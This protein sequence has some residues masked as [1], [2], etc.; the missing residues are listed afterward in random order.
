MLL[1]GTGEVLT[2]RTG[3]AAFT[4]WGTIGPRLPPPRSAAPPLLAGFADDAS[5]LWW[6]TGPERLAAA[7]LW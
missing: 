1:P 2:L 7:V 6:L 4:R 3:D 5:A